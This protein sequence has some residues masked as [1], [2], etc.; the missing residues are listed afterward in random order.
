MALATDD[1]EA[2]EILI[3]KVIF[4]SAV[5]K[6]FKICQWLLSFNV[7]EKHIVKCY[8][9]DRPDIRYCID[10]GT[11]CDGDKIMTN[12]LVIAPN[13]AFYGLY[14]SNPEKYSYFK[15]DQ[16]RW[17]INA[18]DIT[19]LPMSTIYEHIYE[20][21][22]F[23]LNELGLM[24]NVPRTNNSLLQNRDQSLNNVD[25]PTKEDFESAYRT[26]TRLGESVSVDAVLDQIAFC[27]KKEGHSLKYNW[28]MFTEKNIDVWSKKS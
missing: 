1:L 23:K 7:Q 20:S 25:L 22:E 8:Q 24:S 27:A 28:R 6:T 19:E 12:F 9:T 13:F 16:K 26:L 3:Q 10:R 2:A 18:K 14:S 4:G 21:Y 11:D 5:G 15:R 17:R